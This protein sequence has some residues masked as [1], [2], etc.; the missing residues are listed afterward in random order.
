MAVLSCVFFLNKLLNVMIMESISSPGVLL[1]TRVSR[2]A[3]A[4]LADARS[5]SG[6]L[7]MVLE[8]YFMRLD[9]VM[10]NMMT[11]MMHKSTVS[12]KTSR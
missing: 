6:M 1:F 9:R 10:G 5:L 3:S 12:E 8:K 4:A 11:A 2:M 7:L